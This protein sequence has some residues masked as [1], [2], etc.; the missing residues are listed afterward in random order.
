[1]FVPGVPGRSDRAQL[2]GVRAS[3]SNVSAVYPTYVDCTIQSAAER[4]DSG[5]AVN[6]L[7]QE[8]RAVKL[9]H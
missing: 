8:G 6:A 5:Y 4:A 3:S 9:R 1:M 2:G 7:F